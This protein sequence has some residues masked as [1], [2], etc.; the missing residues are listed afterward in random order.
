MATSTIE[1]TT[2]GRPSPSTIG[3][4]TR[5]SGRRTFSSTTDWANFSA[6]SSLA[7]SATRKHTT[8]CR[9]PLRSLSVDT[10]NDFPHSPLFTQIRPPAG[11]LPEHTDHYGWPAGFDVYRRLL[12]RVLHRGRRRQPDGTLHLPGT[13]DHR[14]G[15]I[16]EVTAAPHGN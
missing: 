12:R 15:D 6:Q 2:T 5:A 11:V 3:S 10:A 14:H 13:F 1:R 4:A 16:E 8:R 9:R 7:I